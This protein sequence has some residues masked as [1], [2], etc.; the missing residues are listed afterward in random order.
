M[1]EGGEQMTRYEELTSNLKNIDEAKKPIIL[2]LLKDFVFLEEQIENLRKYPRY[3]I[4]P[5]NP[6]RQQKLPV[7]DLLKDYQAQ[8]NDIATKILRTLDNE[9]GEES[10]LIKALERFNE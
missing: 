9:A 7:H 8:K 1:K 10:P 3:V 4:D 5:N 6:R 2:S